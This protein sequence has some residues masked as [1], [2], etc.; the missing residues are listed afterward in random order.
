MKCSQNTPLINSFPFEST[1]N[2]DCYVSNGREQC[3]CRAGFIGDAYSRCTVPSRSACEPNPCGENAHCVIGGT[4]E[5]TCYCP[6]GM[7]GDPLVGCNDYQCHSDSDCDSSE[8]CL[9]FRCVDP[10]PGSCGIGAKCKVEKHHPACFC[11]NDLIGDA[12][13]RCYAMDETHR[14]PCIPSPCGQNAQCSV[15]NDRAV[16]SCLPDTAGD[17][18]TGCHAECIINSDC[19]GQKACINRRCENPCQSATCGINA[20][21]RVYDHTANCYCKDGFMGD[22]FIHCLSN[23]P[24][25]N[26]TANPCD[27]SPCPIGSVC[28]VYG[29][30]VAVCDVCSNE[31]GYNNPSCRP[32]CLTN[33]DCEFHKACLNQRCLDPCTGTC[34]KNAI[35]TVINHN[36][37]CTCPD[38][39]YGNP[40]DHCSLPLAPVDGSSRGTCDSIQCGA[41][42]E[43]R[44]HSGILACVC[45]TDYYGNPLIGCR[46]ECV[47]SADCE[48]SKSCFNQR[49]VNPCENACGVGAQ[50]QVVNHNAVCYCPAEYSG[51]ALVSC[52]P[53]QRLPPVIY[54]HGH[55]I[56]P[57]DPS[58]CGANSRC[59]VSPTGYAIC[60]CLPNFRG[61]PPACQPECVAHSECPSD[62][63]CVNLKCVDPCY[64]SVCGI[65]ARCEV[66][67]HNPI[68]SCSPGET[69]N[70]FESCHLIPVTGIERQPDN[71]CS[72]SPCGP[73]SICQ[74]KQGHPVCSCV[75]NYIGSPPYCRPECVFNNDCPQNKACIREKCENPCAHTCGAN[76]ECHVISHS[77]FCNCVPGYRGD[78]FIGCSPIP[79]EHDVIDACQPSPCGENSQCAAYNGVAKCSCIPPYI[80]DAYGAGCRPECVYNSDCSSGMACIRQHCRDPCPGVCGSNAQCIVVNHIPVCTCER[81]YQGDAFS[82][83]RPIPRLRKFFNQ[84]FSRIYHFRRSITFSYGFGRKGFVLCIFKEFS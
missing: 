14:S 26:I 30:G 2:A 22:A 21:C 39:L 10:C 82:G 12:L 83:C 62:K 41:N 55:P 65:N 11:D 37:I 17:P 6:Y 8:A 60:S 66:F 81:D 72:P 69:G 71:P 18:Q 47:I 43:C 70:P 44:E 56:N 53:Y 20:D 40:F 7:G 13:I 31:F 4:G 48:L 63:A 61:N 36:A 25:T 23:P 45:Q 46:P 76:A 52:T 19:P 64:G 59:L 33:S 49:C 3:Y 78:A 51:D 38:G 42:T 73:N 9:G 57:C 75:E 5:A 32:E 74:V 34:G 29:N 58:P 24:I 68:C 77:A 27:P 50:C 1:E 79:R 67:N 54:D 28:N 35:C 16:C 15:L 84:F 80:G